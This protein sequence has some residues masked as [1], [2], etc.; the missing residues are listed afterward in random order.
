MPSTLCTL[1]PASKSMWK[2]FCDILRA[3]DI[4]DMKEIKEEKQCTKRLKDKIQDLKA[5]A[6]ISPTLSK[7]FTATLSRVQLGAL[8]PAPILTPKPAV[9]INP[10]LQ[11][12]MQ[13]AQALVRTDAS[14]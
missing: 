7:A 5:K 14:K 4:A 13:T 6:T 3:V 9:A 1:V 2:T 11:M 8:I 12:P 10:G